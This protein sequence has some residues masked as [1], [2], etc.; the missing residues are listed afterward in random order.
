MKKKYIYIYIPQSILHIGL[1]CI[2]STNYGM[3]TEPKTLVLWFKGA[4]FLSA[5]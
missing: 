2:N 4:I 3:A 5:P 1:A